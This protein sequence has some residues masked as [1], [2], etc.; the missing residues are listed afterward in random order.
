MLA[1]DYLVFDR[2]ARGG[3]RPFPVLRQHNGRSLDDLV[4]RFADLDEE[5][6]EA[7]RT[8]IAA[9]LRAIPIP[10]GISSSWA[11][12]LTDEALLRNEISKQKRHIPVRRLIERA[13][14]AL[15]TLKPCFM[16][17]PYAIA[18]HLA[19]GTIQFDLLIIDEASQLKPE[20]SLGALARAEQAVIV[21][22]T[23]AAAADSLLR[24]RRD[25]RRRRRGRAR[26]G[27]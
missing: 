26:H 5:V 15:Q 17:G 16:M 14:A 3:A 21:G 20:E 2:A 10:R 7:R 18:Q 8:Q 6:M 27:R 12:D 4:Q 9:R 22:D 13:G 23:Q 11:G 25:R 19:P 1:L 24:A